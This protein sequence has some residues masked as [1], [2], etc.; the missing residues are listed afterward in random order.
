MNPEKP[1]LS[2]N[3]CLPILPDQASE[4]TLGLLRMTKPHS[5]EPFPEV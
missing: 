2:F 1:T 5:H 3:F 4:L